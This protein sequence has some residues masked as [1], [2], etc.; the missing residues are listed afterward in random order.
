MAMARKRDGRWGAVGL[1][2]AG[3]SASAAQAEPIAIESEPPGLTVRVDGAEP[4]KANGEPVELKLGAH[5]LAIDDPCFE[6]PMQLFKAGPGAR[7]VVIRAKARLVPLKVTSVDL[8]GKPLVAEVTVDSVA[9]GKTPASLRVPLCAKNVR[10]VLPAGQAF[11][12]KLELSDKKIEVVK[13]EFPDVAVVALK[14]TPPEAPVFL[15]GAPAAVSA[16][17]ELQVTPGT[18]TISIGGSCFEPA[19]QQITI[20]L[21]EK[22]DLSLDTKP[23]MATVNV[24]SVSDKGAELAAS[25]SIDGA[26]KGKTPATV[27]APVCSKSIRVALPDGRAWT[28]ALALK[29]GQETVLKASFDLKGTLTVQTDPVGLAV[30]VDGAAASTSTSGL[31]VSAG[32]HVIAIEDRCYEPS[33]ETVTIDDLGS[34]SVLLAGKPRTRRLSVT[35]KDDD[36]DPTTATVLLD[37]KEIGKTTPKEAFIGSISACAKGVTVQG[38]GFAPFETPIDAVAATELK[39]AAALKPPPAKPTGNEVAQPFAI[40]VGLSPLSAGLGVGVEYRVIPTLAF[41]VGVGYSEWLG[42]AAG[43]S[44]NPMPGGWFVDAAASVHVRNSCPDAK[45]QNYLSVC[46]QQNSLPSQAIAVGV[47]VGR[48]FRPMPSISLKVGVGGQLRWHY[49]EQPP[50]ST[51]QPGYKLDQGVVDTLLGGLTLSAGYVF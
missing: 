13:A 30:K 20:G 9:H 33:E 2:V 42:A 25:I 10:V 4:M 44:W 24:T 27:S 48:E 23:L 14:V 22:K 5:K 38:D 18:R 51:V 36:G 50:E 6:A 40:R 15:D 12:S 26:A 16:A 34:K 32:S 39:I 28:N 17:G 29:A 19:S 1:V 35:A 45:Y 43:A 41:G 49:I 8:T 31:S 46:L 21:H 7:P 37:G 3:L 11:E 47:S